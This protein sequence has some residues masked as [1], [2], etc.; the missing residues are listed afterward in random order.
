[1]NPDKIC[2]DETGFVQTGSHVLKFARYN[3]G[4]IQQLAG[5][6]VQ[7]SVLLQYNWTMYNLNRGNF[8]VT[9]AIHTGS[10]DYDCKV[11]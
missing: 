3:P 8:P 11:Y 10:F 9:S 2:P 1:M 5:Y 4:L 7:A 6:P